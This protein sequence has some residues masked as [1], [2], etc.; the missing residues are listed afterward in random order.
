MM[1]GS[2]QILLL[3][4]PS[5]KRVLRDAFCGQES[6]GYYYWPPMDFI[7]LSGTLAKSYH[8]DFLDCI[9][10][11]LNQDRCFSIINSKGYYA[12]IAASSSITW[13]SDNIFF[14]QL[15][16]LFNGKLFVC[17]EFALH[18]ADFILSDCEAVK[19]VISDFTSDHITDFIANPDVGYPGLVNRNAPL[20]K[21]GENKKTFRLEVPLHELFTGK[22]YEL[23]YNKHKP[24]TLLITDY[25]CPYSCKF[26]VCERVDYKTRD[27]FNL[28]E[29]LSYLKKI[30]VREF[31]IIDNCFGCK[32]SHA[33]EVCG[34][35]MKF[36]SWFSWS[37]EMRV[38]VVSEGLL[39]KMQSSGCHTIMLGVES[40]D[41]TILRNNNKHFSKGEIFNA[42]SLIKKHD[43]RTV[44]YFLFGLP[45]QSIASIL[46]D[47]KNS[48]MLNPD[49]ASYSIAQFMD[50]TS[51]KA[52]ASENPEA[53]NNRFP[54]TTL[55]KK[56]L[57]KLQRK[58][59]IEFYANPV[60][61][62]RVLRIYGKGHR[63]KILFKD[64]TSLFRLL[65]R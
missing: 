62:I 43:I 64:I 20:S 5:Q 63:L 50:G 29:E 61:F 1:Q 53:H 39:A 49:F 25:G 58:A 46:S 42:V 23:P 21:K 32:K 52:Y 31:R 28:E 35:I 40:F 47:I 7:A 2:K 45:G 44:A 6:K 48:K 33:M 60:K 54:G 55:T 3:N 26:C 19:G 22:K 10:D 8:I 27:L 34:V 51:L 59:F 17:G 30:G 41:E 36:G 16:K 13:D 24:F 65:F 11:N 4:P 12:I 37:C 9:A 57:N 56:Q 14:S 15:E 38:D 18:N